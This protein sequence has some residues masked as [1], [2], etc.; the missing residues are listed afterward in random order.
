M[1]ALVCDE[2]TIRKKEQEFIERYGGELNVIAAHRT[3]EER[4]RNRKEKNR[5][6]Y[7]DRTDKVA[8]KERVGAYYRDNRRDVLERVL[9]KVACDCGAIVAWCN[10]PRHRRTKKH[11]DWAL[12]VD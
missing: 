6:F 9:R 10:L 5:R 1:V 11:L 12:D 2:E 7:L 3:P 4:E 8:N